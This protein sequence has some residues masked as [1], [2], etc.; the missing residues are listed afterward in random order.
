[1]TTIPDRTAEVNASSV[2]RESLRVWRPLLW[3]RS[4]PSYAVFLGCL[5]AIVTLHYSFMRANGMTVDEFTHLQAGYR[6]WQ[7][8]EFAN[9]PEHPP[10]AK[11]VAALP[12]RS[13]QITGFPTPCGKQAIVSQGTSQIALALSQ[14]AHS[15]ELLWKARTAMLVFPILLLTAVF[16]AT[17]RWF[18][19]MAAAMAAILVTFEPTLV[20]HSSLVT[21]DAALATFAFITVWLAVEFV[22][23]PSS[24][25]LLAVALALGLALASKHSA[26]ILPVILL[27]IMLLARHLDGSATTISIRRLLVSWA[28]I[29]AIA[30]A[31][32]WSAYGFRYG[33]LPHEIQPAYDFARWF[34][35]VGMD[36]SFIA[37]LVS[38]LARHRL[39]PEAYLAGI[40]EIVTTG[41]RPAFFL[42]RIYLTG[43]WYYFPVA[44]A[45]KTTLGVL[46]LFAVAIALPQYWMR[47]KRVVAPLLASVVMLLCIAMTSKLN[48][49]VRHVLPVFPFLIV[50][51]AGGA[52]VLTKRAGRV[53]IVVLI[54]I[55]ASVVSGIHAAPA[56]L[57]YAN[58]IF[59]GPNRLHHLLG[60]SNLDWGQSMSDL[61]SYLSAR[62]SNGASECAVVPAMQPHRHARCVELPTFYADVIS[63]KFE[64]VLPEEFEG[65]LVLQ[66]LAVASSSAYLPYLNR[67]PDEIAG[68]GTIL[69]YRGKFDF[70]E[71][72]ALRRLH[73]G[74][75][76]MS[77]AGE[78]WPS[79]GARATATRAAE[80]F[81]AAEPHCP[82]T[83]RVD[84]E[85]AYT[86]SL[87]AQDRWIEAQYHAEQLL[88]L[89]DNMPTYRLQ[90]QVILDALRLQR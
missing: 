40:S 52:S 53:R 64:P 13:W 22:D 7:C 68:H 82:Q 56:Q 62:S 79:P 75:Y 51:A 80:E 28:C 26:A 15:A 18:G 5:V 43:I 8:G 1:M 85:L 31:V 50:L 12:V 32:L 4:L 69:V 76:L 45:I 24:W 73:R 2:G 72:A 34:H 81:A 55:G 77:V 66:P 42:G 67:E 16:A 90:R 83:N 49:G 17:R 84:L 14:S 27:V 25:R 65:T 35:A 60:D 48:I 37:G 89:T 3:R 70:R 33:A 46:L 20:A 6:Y 11:L 88:R 10:L 86:A 74:L 29:G 41:S 9:N 78:S 19:N 39:L 30:V 87:T 38:F 36:D 57:S 71:I 54:L 59:G 44:L 47:H 61:D 63:D 21:T 58:E 23:H